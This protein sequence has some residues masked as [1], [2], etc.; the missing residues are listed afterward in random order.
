MRTYKKASVF[1]V[2]LLSGLL[3]SSV[4]IGQAQQDQGAQGQQGGA[5]TEQEAQSFDQREL[6]QF[7][8]A[9]V[10]V[11]EIHTEYSQRLQEVES[12]DEAQSLQQ[13]ANDEMVQA[14]QDTGLEVQDYS[15]IAAALERDPQMREQVVG[16]IEER[17]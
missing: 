4:A 1:M 7:A 13:E 12:T 9:Y 11:G 14:I 10:K 16:M 6:E 3:F 15:A 8:D 5:M 17:Q 2:P